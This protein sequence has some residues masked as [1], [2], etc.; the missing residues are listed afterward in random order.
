[1]PISQARFC[2]LLDAADDVLR[3]YQALAVAIRLA[4]SLDDTEVAMQR[5]WSAMEGTAPSIDT[6]KAIVAEANHFT[7]QK[8][9]KNNR[10]A[11]RR[12]ASRGQSRPGDDAFIGT[13]ATVGLPPPRYST[14]TPGFRET[15]GIADV[16]I[17]PRAPDRA[18]LDPMAPISPPVPKGGLAAEEEFETDP[19]YDDPNA[20]D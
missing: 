15:M 6:I 13:K 17:S 1:M 2:S 8:M 16:P 19:A 7:K 3:K 18:S 9:H 10:D 5:C 4:R 14:P 12:R 11:A 20:P